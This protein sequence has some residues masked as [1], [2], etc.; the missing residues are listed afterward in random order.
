MGSAEEGVKQFLNQILTRFHGIRLKS[1]SNPF[2][3]RSKSLQIMCF[4]GKGVP[5]PGWKSTINPVKIRSNPSDPICVRPHLPGADSC[6]T[7][8]VVRCYFTRCPQ[9]RDKLQRLVFCLRCPRCKACLWTAIGHFHGVSQESRN[10]QKV[11]KEY[12]R[13]F[14]ENSFLFYAQGALDN[15]TAP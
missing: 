10:C 1:G 9:K 13:D 11:L 15:V 6:P 7:M 3:I 2:K 12:R 5:R 14:V 4:G 8:T